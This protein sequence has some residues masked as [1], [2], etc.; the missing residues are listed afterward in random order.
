[1]GV[2]KRFDSFRYTK[3]MS[4][5]E[6]SSQAFYSSCHGAIQ[7]DGLAF[8]KVSHL[9]SSHRLGQFFV[10]FIERSI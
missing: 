2:K 8:E 9:S 3:I 7:K 5:V 10:A 4:F 6:G 1:M